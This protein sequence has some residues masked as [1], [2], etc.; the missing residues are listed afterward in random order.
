MKN[1][2]R[3]LIAGLLAGLT[4]LSHGQDAS[5]PAVPRFDGCPSDRIAEAFDDVVNGGAIDPGL[6]R[7]IFDP[8]AQAIAPNQV[9]DG[10][11]QV[12][13]CWVSSYAIR[14]ADGVVLIDTVHEPHVDTWLGNLRRVGIDP[15]EVR[16]VLI[17]HGHFDHAGGAYRLKP[18]APNARFVMTQRGWDEAARSAA[19]SAGTPGAWRMIDRDVVASDGERFVVGGVPFTVYETPGHTMGTASFS[20]PVR[21]GG[22]TYRAITIGGL[23]LNAIES[24]A[25]AAAY[26][27][28]IERIEAMTALENDP[29]LVHLSTHAFSNGQTERA[30]LNLHRPPGIVNVLVDPTGLR[31]QLESLRMAAQLRLV[32]EKAA[33]R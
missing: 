9:F 16:L 2:H 22:Q 26:I 15:A 7:W 12:G 8:R 32:K 4:T 20:Y 14:T 27:A 28:S 18:L 31:K 13:I 6:R 21:D 3:V 25:Q 33:G 17:T 30:Q 1:A 23:G 29:V 24:S 11:W 5:G 19:A 10:V